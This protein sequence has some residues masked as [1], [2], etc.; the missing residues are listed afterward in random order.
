[1]VRAIGCII[2]VQQ[3]RY[4]PVFACVIDAIDKEDPAHQGE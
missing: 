2:F 1:M 4:G 3:A